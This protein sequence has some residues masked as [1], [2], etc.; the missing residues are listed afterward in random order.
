[1]KIFIGSDH[2]GFNLKSA[3][4]EKLK[5]EGHEVLDLGTDS[6]DSCHYPEFAIT[7][8][9][10]VSRGNGVGI[11]V[12]GSG[13]GVSMVANR[14]QNIRAALCRTTTEAELS[15]QHNNS[16]IICLGERLT[17]E[18]FAFDIVDTW[19]NTE[20][21]GGRHQGRVDLF[22]SLGEKV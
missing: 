6:T 12:C 8:A 10:E 5:V 1:M 15:R 11:L 2:A 4:F 16:N 22:N 21:E 13:I 3:I 18:A 14:F 20:F 7:V 17:Q 9:K 19:L